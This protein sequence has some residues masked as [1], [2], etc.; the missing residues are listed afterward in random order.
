[1]GLFKKGDNLYSK[2]STKP[3]PSKPLE[4][5]VVE[6]IVI[7]DVPFVDKINFDYL[8]SPGG[9]VLSHA[10]LLFYTL[11]LNLVQ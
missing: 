11:S 6:R 10:P 3:Q 1:M 9:M 2:K 4:E 5:E 7:N 8:P